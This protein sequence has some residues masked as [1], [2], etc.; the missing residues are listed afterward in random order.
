MIHPLESFVARKNNFILQHFKKTKYSK[1]IRQF[2][3]AHSGESCFII[4]N[5]P[6]LRVEDLD[7]IVSQHIPT[8]AFNR[9][10]LIFNDTRWRPTYYFSQDEKVLKNCVTEVNEMELPYKFIPL[11]LH[12]YNDISINN[13]IYFNT[14]NE[15]INHPIFLEQADDKVCYSTTVAYT[16]AQFA[17][18]M[19]FKKIYLIGVDH[20]FSTY[21]NDKGEIITDST[22]K[23]YFSDA[24]NKDKSELYIPN[25]DA[26]TRAFQTMKLYCD[27]HGIE[28]YNVTRSGKL[29]V[30][31]R[32]DFDKL[33]SD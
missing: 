2:R 6:S 26:S 29:E 4:G 24:Y 20:N 28:V 25:I 14:D 3:N 13:A 8:F 33:F 12:Y 7:K 32:M 11:K 23:D 1:I 22:A 21:Q 5:G 30:F 10:Y 18:Y 15:H 19:G 9:I 17:V 27:A 31:P 16:A